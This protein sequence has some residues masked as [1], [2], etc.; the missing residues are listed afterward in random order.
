M[1][2]RKQDWGL[3]TK[4]LAA[5]RDAVLEVVQREGLPDI[6][7]RCRSGTDAEKEKAAELIAYLAYNDGQCAGFIVAAGGIPPLIAMLHAE[8]GR[9]DDD[10]RFDMKEV[11]VKAL[12]ALCEGDPSNQLPI[13]E[14]GAIPPM[15]KILTE[16]HHPWSIREAAA[17]AIALL[18]YEPCG[19]PA[20]EMITDAGGVHRMVAVYRDRDCKGA[21]IH[22]GLQ[23]SKARDEGDGHP[24]AA[25][26]GSELG[27]AH[28]RFG[29]PSNS[30][31]LGVE[32][33]YFAA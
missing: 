4:E 29:A 1:A 11:A 12:H 9:G 18:A 26:A 23:A 21:Q 13:A 28:G 33:A 22:G 20:Q 15:L 14:R 6:I 30:L 8:D 24:C 27:C 25:R 3:S 7:G 10:P 31:T 17:N 16:D 32:S 5:R 19:G 2:L